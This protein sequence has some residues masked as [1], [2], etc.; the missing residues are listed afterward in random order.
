MGP[1]GVSTYMDGRRCA[2]LALLFFIQFEAGAELA[3][4][5]FVSF[6]ELPLFHVSPP[7]RRAT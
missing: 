1:G 3:V 2:A 4:Q 7:R 6:A 5:I